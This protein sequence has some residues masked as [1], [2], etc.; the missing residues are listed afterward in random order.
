M[1]TLALTNPTTGFLAL[2]KTM[3][4]Q[5][6]NEDKILKQLLPLENAGDPTN[7]VTPDFIGQLCID[8]S[9]SNAYVA[10]TAASSG[11]TKLN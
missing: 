9:N 6:V 5:L 10:I 1:G 4:N 2:K 7:A 11:W 8:T 3:G